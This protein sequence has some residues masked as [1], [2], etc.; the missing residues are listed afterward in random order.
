[1]YEITNTPALT[2]LDTD[3]PV[4]N[5]TADNFNNISYITEWICERV[6]EVSRKWADG[7]VIDE[8]DASQIKEL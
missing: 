2:T 5:Q 1:M 8:E 3:R 7:F 4:A 6:L